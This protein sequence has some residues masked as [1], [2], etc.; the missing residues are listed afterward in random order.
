MNRLNYRLTFGIVLGVLGAG[1]AVGFFFY[2]HNHEANA[3]SAT[4]AAKPAE[5]VEKIQPDTILLP[6]SVVRTLSIKTAV[7]QSASHSRQLAPLNGSLAL[8]PDR[9]ARVHSRFAGEVVEIGTM[10][11]PDPSGTSQVSTGPRQVCFG[12]RVEKGQLLA[13]VW[14]KDLGEK[15][16]ELVDAL[17]QL[18]V[19]RDSLDRLKSLS[20]GVIAQRQLREAERAVE[21]THVAIAR[22]EATLR[23]WRV[24]EEEIEAVVA[25][26]ERLGRQDARRE[27]DTFKRWARVEVRAPL[28]GTILEKNLAV[29]DIVDTTTDMFRVADLSRLCVWVHAYEEDLPALLALPKPIRWT[30]RL[31]ADPKAA[32]LTGTIDKIGELIDPSQHTALVFGRV[33]N[34]D[35]R[36][37]SGQFITASVEEP[38]PTGEMVIPTTALVEDGVESVVMVQEDPARFAYTLRNV[39]VIARYQDVVHVRIRGTGPDKENLKGLSPG[40]HVVVAGAVELRGALADLSNSE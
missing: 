10:N 6:A 32:Q 12:D 1:V 36:M 24:S 4:E 9:L 11:E 17:S 37:R 38:P 14:S 3:A 33:D 25:E 40:E 29:G 28:A 31:K 7:V 15:K 16:S 8:D 13:V 39:N 5:R 2:Q 21:T 27:A 19:N 34:R 35:G 18:R 22:A 30:I 26:A 23:T 20:D